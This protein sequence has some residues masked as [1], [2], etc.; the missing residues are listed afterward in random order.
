[1]MSPA[2]TLETRNKLD[3][4]AASAATKIGPVDRVSQFMRSTWDNDWVH[5]DGPVLVS[6]Y[7]SEATL[8]GGWR[9]TPEAITVHGQCILSAIEAAH[10]EIARRVLEETE[11][12]A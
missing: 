5:P 4:L 6:I 10:R 7:F 8:P 1:M 3:A 2:E 9:R 12:A 11:S